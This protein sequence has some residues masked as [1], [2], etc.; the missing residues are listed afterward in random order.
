MIYIPNTYS[1]EFD[2][3][4]TDKEESESATVATSKVLVKTEVVDDSKPSL[5]TK[6]TVASTPKRL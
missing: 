1:P 6:P 3:F 5:E 2:V 4:Q